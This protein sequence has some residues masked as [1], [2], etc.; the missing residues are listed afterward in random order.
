MQSRRMV[1]FAIAATMLGIWLLPAPAIAQGGPPPGGGKDLPAFDDVVKEHEKIEGLFDFYKKDGSYLM[2]VKPDQL[3]RD[4][5]VSVTRDTGIGQMG[6]LASQVLGEGPVRFHKVGENLQLLLRNTRFVALDDADI[7]RAV[8]RSF[9]DS[10]LGAASL[11]CQPHSKTNAVLVDAT[12]FF[13]TDIE[14]IGAFLAEQFKTPYKEDEKNSSL[15]GIKAFPMNVE[16]AA[17]VHFTGRLPAPFV[18]LPDPRSLFITYRY[19]IS[20]IPEPSDFVPRIADDRVGHFPAMF[21]DF[22]DDRRDE[23]YVRY[24]SRWNLQKE[25]PYA[26]ASRPV[27]PI[28]YWLENTIPKKYRKAIADGTL[29]WNDAFKQIGFEDAVVVKQQPDDADWDPADARYSTVRWFMGTDASFAIGPSRHNHL[30][31]Q[32]YDADIG[33][34]DGLVRNRVREYVELADPVSAINALFEE[35]ASMPRRGAD[36]R[37]S[38]SLATGALAQVGFGYDVLSVRGIEPGSDE[39]NAYVNGFITYVQAHE[40]GHTLG[41]RHNFRASVIH[42]VETLQDVGRTSTQGLTGSVMD[43]VPVNLAR[44]DETQGEYWQTRLGPYDYWAIEYAYRPFPGIQNPEGELP[45]LRRIASRVAEAGLGYGTDEDTS[46]PRTNVWDLGADP[47]AFYGNRVALVE[48]LWREMTTELAREGEGYQLMRQ[49]FGRGLGQFALAV[50]NVSKT[51]GGM[52]THRDH[53]ADPQERLPLEPVSADR[54]REAMDFVTRHLFETSSFDLP[55]E[56]LNRLAPSRWWDFSF[57]IFSSPRLEFPLHDAVLAIQSNLLGVL[58]S[59]VKLDRLVDMEMH[60]PP[61]GARFTMAD[62]FN[63]LHG[64][65]WSEVRGPGTPEIGSFRRALQREHLDRLIGLMVDPE[66]GVPE[67]AGTLARANLVDLK[68]RIESALAGGA[69]DGAT[70]AHLDETR[71]RIEAALSARMLR[72]QQS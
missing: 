61:G 64:A 66:P 20:E 19:S 22:S 28:T 18:N 6:L 9:S 58:Y 51:I 14:G 25:Q 2:A 48:D 11:K 3:D 54:Q 36:P 45:E 30:T 41:L 72:L 10:L 49:A 21:Q 53:V 67:D 23:P 15:S 29:M 43:Y 31:G 34:S 32:I 60:F 59:P 55:P 33:W 1:S 42:P 65:I 56:V 13:I 57:S 40:V 50:F 47:L 35:M 27:E 69:L 12:P 4:Y 70:R 24:V 8:D 63:E 71:A 68:G 16:V 52:H 26:E 44:K 5:M 7:R 37:F 39:E 62:M 46:D 17:I 38:C